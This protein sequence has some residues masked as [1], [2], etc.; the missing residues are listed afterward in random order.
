LRQ[1]GSFAQQYDPKND[2]YKLLGVSAKDDPKK[3][4]IAYYKLA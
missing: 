3:I 2:Y 4:K 1:F